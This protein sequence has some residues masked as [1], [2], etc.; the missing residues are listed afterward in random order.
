[1]R[2]AKRKGELGFGGTTPPPL[3]V[4]VIPLKGIQKNKEMLIK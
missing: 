4:D 3:T 2:K 1:M